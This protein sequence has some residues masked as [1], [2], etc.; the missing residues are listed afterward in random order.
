MDFCA[1]F[2]VDKAHPDVLTVMLQLFDEVKY[3]CLA[4]VLFLRQETLLHFVFLHPGPSYT[5][6]GQQIFIQ[7]IRVRET[8]IALSSCEQR[9]IQMDSASHVFNIWGQD[10]FCWATPFWPAQVCKNA[11]CFCLV[12]WPQAL[13]SGYK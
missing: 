6:A 4:V 7:L 8:N 1:F 2:Q 9:F 5:E 3:L 12:G 11:K 10:R 13:K